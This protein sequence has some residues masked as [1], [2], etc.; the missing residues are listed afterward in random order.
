MSIVRY[1]YTSTS[2]FLLFICYWVDGVGI[3]T[4]Y[5]TFD[6]I[7]LLSVVKIQYGIIHKYF[8]LIRENYVCYCFESFVAEIHCTQY[9][10][11]CFFFVFELMVILIIDY[12]FCHCSSVLVNRKDLVLILIFLDII[13][14]YRKEVQIWYYDTAIR[15]DPYVN[16]SS[17]I[18]AAKVSTLF[19]DI[20]WIRVY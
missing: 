7:M 18:Y 9:T 3:I 11:F 8:I 2:F 10:T 14:I 15:S 13:R 12:N 17:I 1:I 19:N 16:V 5:N 4:S 20:Q 6:D